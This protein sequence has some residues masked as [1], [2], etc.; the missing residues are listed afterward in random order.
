MAARPVRGVTSFS[1][2]TWHVIELGDV[3]MLHVRDHAHRCCAH[4]AWPYHVASI[5]RARDAGVAAAIADR[6]SSIG[7]EAFEKS[8][9]L[10]GTITYTF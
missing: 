7:T 4:M 5:R 2:A 10:L 8:S 6:Q 1:W 9:A 3:T